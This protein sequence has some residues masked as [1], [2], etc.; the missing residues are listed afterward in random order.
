M[1][2]RRICSLYI[3][4]EMY[5]GVRILQHY[6][7]IYRRNMCHNIHNNG[8]SERQLSVSCVLLTSLCTYIC[9]QEYK[10]HFKPHLKITAVWYIAVISSFNR[11]L[12]N[13][14]LTEEKCC[15]KSWT[16]NI[17]LCKQKF[18]ITEFFRSGVHC[19]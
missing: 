6:N 9:L 3:Y 17:V 13:V 16:W 4:I 1:K 15:T 2:S 11:S 5:Y 7:N 14:V 19:I 10:I 12:F 8:H 18:F